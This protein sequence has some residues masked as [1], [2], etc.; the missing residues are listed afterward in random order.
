[1]RATLVGALPD[2]VVTGKPKL[3]EGPSTL[4]TAH[5]C[6][7]VPAR[8]SRT[9][10]R[11]RVDA[12][13]WARHGEEIHQLIL[14]DTAGHGLDRFEVPTLN[15]A[16]VRVLSHPSHELALFEYAMG[17]DG[18]LL[19]AA[20]AQEGKIRVRELLGPDDAVCAG[21]DGTG[22]RLL[23]L[24]YPSAPETVR[25]VSWPEWEEVARL[26]AGTVGAEQGWGTAGCFADDGSVLLSS[27]GAG[28]FHADAV[29]DGAEPV[30][31]DSPAAHGVGQ[32]A[33]HLGEIKPLGGRHY[34]VRSWH[35]GRWVSTEWE[36][37]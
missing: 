4:G 9:P 23:L 21:F 29:L 5:L 22:Q 37:G 18:A 14:R 2:P 1:M 11:H 10:Q 32:R 34:G 20:W 17:Q 26:D 35:E 30:G 8:S 31:L 15:H 25:V 28:L 27:P 36:L 7:R 6:A 12:V 3:G 16:W 24:P 13:A 19:F 33:V